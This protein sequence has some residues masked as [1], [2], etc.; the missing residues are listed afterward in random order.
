MAHVR[1]AV[2]VRE[3]AKGRHARHVTDDADV[4][5]AVVHRGAGRDAHA[6]AVVLAVGD[7]DEQDPL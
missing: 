2:E 6:A 5:A 7:R 4:E 1:A 3:L